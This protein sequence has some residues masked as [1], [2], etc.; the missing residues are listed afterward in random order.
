MKMLHH[1]FQLFVHGGQIDGISS[2]GG[3]AREM[4]SVD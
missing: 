3:A 2:D 4:T 1:I